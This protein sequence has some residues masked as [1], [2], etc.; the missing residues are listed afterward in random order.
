MK[1]KIN[2]LIT[3]ADKTLSDD[4]QNQLVNYVDFILDWNDKQLNK[5]S[6]LSFNN[7]DNLNLLRSKIKKQNN[8]KLNFY[9]FTSFT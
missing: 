5:W 1:S 4:V 2:K 7:F 9:F 3:I 8:L 6:E